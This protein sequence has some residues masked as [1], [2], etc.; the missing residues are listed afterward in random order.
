MAKRKKLEEKSKPYKT[1]DL[2]FKKKF[3][4]S[5]TQEQIDDFEKLCKKKNIKIP[6]EFLRKLLNDELEQ[7]TGGTYKNIQEL[8]EDSKFHDFWIDFKTKLEDFLSGDENNIK[9]QQAIH[10]QIKKRLK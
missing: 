3:T 9:I 4:I 1:I 5:W 8:A 10:N 2:L 7:K 6:L